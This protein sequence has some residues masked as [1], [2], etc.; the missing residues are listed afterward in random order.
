MPGDKHETEHLRLG[1]LEE[2]YLTARR[3]YRVAVRVHL[4]ETHGVS[5]TGGDDPERVHASL[6]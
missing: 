3:A 2:W 1:D 4:E 6:H 5:V